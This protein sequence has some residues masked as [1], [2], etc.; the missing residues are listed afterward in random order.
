[1]QPTIVLVG[2]W[3]VGDQIKDFE[4]TAY[5]LDGS[6]FVFTG[7]TG[8]LV[9]RSRDNRGNTINTACAFNNPATDGISRVSSLGTLLTLTSGRK[10]EIYVCN[11]KWTRISDSKLLKSKAFALAISLDPQAA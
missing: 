2:T 10:S 8:S 4:Y 1:M 11:F 3:Y 5:K 6:L 9:G 7:Y